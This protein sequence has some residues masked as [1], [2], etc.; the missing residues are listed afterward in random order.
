MIISPSQL[1][2]VGGAGVVQRVSMCEH[3]LVEGG[4]YSSNDMQV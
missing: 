3:A 2:Y 4:R 1:K